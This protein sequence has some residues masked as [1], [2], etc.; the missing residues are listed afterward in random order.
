M[1]NSDPIVGYS[2]FAES[3]TVGIGRRLREAAGP[4][5]G[6][7]LLHQK[8]SLFLVDPFNTSFTSIK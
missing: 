6:H 4:Q 3:G 2:T 8:D 5:V 1:Q 7:S